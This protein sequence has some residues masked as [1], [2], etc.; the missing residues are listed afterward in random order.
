MVTI[1][2]EIL[3]SLYALCVDIVSS[4]GHGSYNWFLHEPVFILV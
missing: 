4:W 3:P 2:G 1:V